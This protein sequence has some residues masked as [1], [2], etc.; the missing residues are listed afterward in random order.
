MVDTTCRCRLLELTCYRTAQT[1]DAH[2]LQEICTEPEGPAVAHH[3]NPIPHTR[4]CCTPVARRVRKVRLVGSATIVVI[5]AV[6]RPSIRH[7]HGCPALDRR[8]TQVLSGADRV[9][10]CCIILIIRTF[11][12]VDGGSSSGIVS[13]VNFPPPI[14]SL[15]LTLTLTLRTSSLS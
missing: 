6:Y 12:W 15:T 10:Q 4:Y 3:L 9:H 7:G 11:L 8:H 5:L 14:F 2:T 13:P 1:L